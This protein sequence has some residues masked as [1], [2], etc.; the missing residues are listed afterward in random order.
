MARTKPPPYASRDID[1]GPADWSMLALRTIAKALA[2]MK[3]E[4]A[5][6]G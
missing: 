5:E 3:A 6:A 1:F 2:G 4:K